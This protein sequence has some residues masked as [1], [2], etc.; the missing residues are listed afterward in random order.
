M[1]LG[2]RNERSNKATGNFFNVPT[3]RKRKTNCLVTLLFDTRR[4]TAN[5]GQQTALAHYDF[6]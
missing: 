1:D 6:L 3:K 2:N 4:T 5:A